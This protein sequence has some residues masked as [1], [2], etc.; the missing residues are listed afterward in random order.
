MYFKNLT[1]GDTSWTQIT[2]LENVNLK[3]DATRAASNSTNPHNWNAM[4]ARIVGAIGIFD[5]IS[6]G[7]DS[8]GNALDFNGT[9]NYVNIGNVPELSFDGVLPYTFEAWVKPDSAGSGGYIIGKF[10]EGLSVGTY[11]FDVLND[12]RIRSSRNISP[13]E[14][15]SSEQILSDEYSH[16]ATTYDGATLRVYINGKDAGSIVIGNTSS[17]SLPVMIGAAQVSGSPG[18]F[19]DGAVDELRVWNVA[20]TP[21]E[22]QDNMHNTLAGS[23]SGLVAYYRFDHTS[24]KTLTDLTSYGNDGTLTNM[25]GTEWTGS[26]AFNTW[27]GSTNTD[28]NT[29]SNWT[30]G[31]P[32]STDNVGIPSG[33]NQPTISSAGN[34]NHLV[35]KT[36][37]TLTISGSSTLAV[38]GNWINNGTFAAGTGTVTLNGGNQ[39]IY[40]S[41]TFNNLVKNVA[42][43]ATLTFENGTTQAVSGNFDLQGASG[44]LLS[45]RSSSDGTQWQVNPSG[46][47]TVAYLDVK[48]SGNTNGTVID[49]SGTNTVDSG[50]NSGWNFSIPVIDQASPVSQAMDEG[51]SPTAWIAPT[52][53]ASDGD[54]DTITWGVS[55]PAANGTATVSGTGASPS[56]FTYAPDADYNGSDSFVIQAADAF[57][58]DTITV[59]VTVNAVND[60]PSFTKG[61]DQTVNEDAGAQTA[62]GWATSISKGPANES[63]QTLTFNVSND[64][65]SLFSAQPAIDASGNLTYTSAADANGSTIV[66]VSLSD[67]GGGADTSGNQ[68][69][70]ITVDAVNDTPSFT[71]GADQTVN[72]DAG[73]QTASGWATSISKGPANESGQTLTFN[74]SNDN[75]SLFS[76]QPAIDASG[77]LTYTPGTD[78][79]GST[80]VTVS[81]EEARCPPTLHWDVYCRVGGA[82]R[83]PPFELPFSRS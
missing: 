26:A 77:N 62:N 10:D 71:K 44:N 60:T 59:D 65:N 67:D 7:M 1:A 75:N 74:V 19:F 6:I 25:A 29:A 31:I 22:I 12:G 63:G 53:T 4:A 57:G 8:P 61:A 81:L 35:I 54:G 73:A 47:R 13:W 5:N 79:N 83:N 42:S 49:A 32:A 18:G 40:G 39:A 64:N 82:Q 68:T 38:S 41:N 15:L 33:G 52:V 14:V 69:F 36:G 78:A 56:T 24:G 21:T 76:A 48:D 66:T 30:N 27:T 17:T 46:T 37:A 80:T 43:A 9:N 72:E 23:E 20:R 3:L 28:W 55:T 50:N 11:L 16:I 51:G 70:T 34:C 58:S 2:G 45:L